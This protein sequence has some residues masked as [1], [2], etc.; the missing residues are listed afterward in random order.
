MQEW[1]A[2]ILVSLQQQPYLA[3]VFVAMYAVT[4]IF[5]LPGFIF[6]YSAGILFGPVLGLLMIELGAVIGSSAAF[7]ISRYFVSDRARKRAEMNGLLSKLDKVVKPDD[8]GL[9]LLVRLCPLIPFRAS[10]YAFGITKI[11]YRHFLAGTMLGILP[12]AS[13]YSYAGILLGSVTKISSAGFL[14]G[15]PN[16]RIGF[17]SVVGLSSIALCVV[18]YRFAKRRLEQRLHEEPKTSSFTKPKFANAPH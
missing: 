8:F 6:T 2:Q 15:D 17:I 10:N 5:L 3:P 14:P 11:S 13:I 12:S 1:L 16:L 9:V 4:C 18:L 7:F